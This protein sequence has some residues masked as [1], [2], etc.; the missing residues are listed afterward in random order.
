MT[1]EKSLGL[2]SPPMLALPERISPAYSLSHTGSGK[3]FWT[4]NI[5]FLMVRPL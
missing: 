4:G 1:L 3:I 5:Y 2:L